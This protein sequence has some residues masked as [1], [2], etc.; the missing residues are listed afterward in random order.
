MFQKSG[1]AWDFLQ[2][3][4]RQT[5]MFPHRSSGTFLSKDGDK[6]GI[7]VFGIFSNGFSE[8]N[9]NSFDIKQIILN[10]KRNPRMMGVFFCFFRLVVLRGTSCNASIA[11]Q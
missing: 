9:R 6:S 11:R 3:F 7:V 2:C 8:Y 10:L 4:H 1:I 5:I